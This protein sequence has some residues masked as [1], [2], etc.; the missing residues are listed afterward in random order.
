VCVRPE[1]SCQPAFSTCSG[2]PSD[3]PHR[4]VREIKPDRQLS[5]DT[6]LVPGRMT[7]HAFS[8]CPPQDLQ[9]RLEVLETR[10]R[11]MRR[12]IGVDPSDRKSGYVRGPHVQQGGDP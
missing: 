1:A 6:R 3:R 11:R 7:N 2:I 12:N 5:T 10:L 8:T 9:A 4:S